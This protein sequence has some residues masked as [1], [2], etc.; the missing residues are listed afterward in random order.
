MC[1]SKLFTYE[2]TAA[3]VLSFLFHLFLLYCYYYSV[4]HAT[5]MPVSAYM[6]LAFV[7]GFIQIN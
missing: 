5:V 1:H 3:F 7:F 2:Y 6:A 4:V